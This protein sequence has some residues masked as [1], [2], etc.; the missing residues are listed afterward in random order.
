MARKRPHGGIRSL[1]VM[2]AGS[3]GA[4]RKK[5]INPQEG[6]PLALTCLFRG[7]SAKEQDNEP[8]IV[9][10]GLLTMAKLEG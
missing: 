3:G 4:A 7:E 2:A 8:C 5:A 6:A 1:G 10:R 9:S